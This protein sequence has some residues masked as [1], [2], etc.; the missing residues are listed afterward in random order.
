VRRV[1]QGK[2]ASPCDQIQRRDGAT[3]K[4]SK[5]RDLRSVPSD[6]HRFTRGYASEY[7]ASVIAQV[8]YG[9]SIHAFRVSPVIHTDQK[10]VVPVDKSPTTEGLE[11][12]EGELHRACEFACGDAGAGQSHQPGGFGDSARL[13]ET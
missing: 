5:F 6:D 9:H 3:T 11:E 4:R 2:S 7:I 8:A 10:Q 13:D 1:N 12:F